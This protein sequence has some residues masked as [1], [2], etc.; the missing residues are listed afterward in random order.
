MQNRGPIEVLRMLWRFD[1]KHRQ[2]IEDAAKQWKSKGSFDP[3][4]M[5]SLILRLKASRI[6]HKPRQ[7]KVRLRGNAEQLDE[8][9]DKQIVRMLPY[10]R[11]DQAQSVTM[12]YL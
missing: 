12:R 7:F 4:T 1:P 11:S 3:K 9:N 5:A 6:D 2:E 8:L 10:L